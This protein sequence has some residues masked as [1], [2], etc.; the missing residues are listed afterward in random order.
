MDKRLR[1]QLALA[2]P[3]PYEIAY[4]ACINAH[5]GVAYCRVYDVQLFL[6]LHPSPVRR[7]CEAF[8]PVSAISHADGIGRIACLAFPRAQFSRARNHRSLRNGGAESAAGLS[9]P[10]A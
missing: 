10:C 7:A 9:R 6:N 2:H 8:V 4:D 5:A 1:I 3:R